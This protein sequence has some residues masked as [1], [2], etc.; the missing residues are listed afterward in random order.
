ML[1]QEIVERNMKTYLD[2]A[3]RIL[4]TKKFEFHHNSEWLAKLNYREIGEQ[5]DLFSVAEFIG[6]ENIKKRLSERKRVSL[7]EMLYPLMQGYDSVAIRADVELG[8]TDQ[9]FNLLAGRRMQEHFN[10]AA[11]DILMNDLIAGLDGRKMSSSWGNV[12][13]IL[14]SPEE[15]FGKIM[16]MR[17]DL[18]LPYFIHCTRVSLD[19][20]EIFKKELKAGKNP[21]EVKEELA[22]EITKMY[23]QEKGAQ[24]GKSYFQ[25]VFQDK[26]IPEQIPEIVLKVSQL[27][28]LDLLVQTKLC[29]SKSEARDMVE[30]GAVKIDQ[31]AISDWQMIVSGLNNKIV[32]MG[33]RRFC[34][35]KIKK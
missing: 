28:I 27:N 9:R 14:D 17:D 8:G 15:M 7:R 3:G 16:S 24:K 23:W 34:R 20:L 29:A 5:A 2:Q 32:Q 6:R 13:N 30:Q 25:L 1:K 33:K 11:Q 12:I 19:R 22:F 35:I 18:I 10:Q 31:A 4:D 21:K 26:K